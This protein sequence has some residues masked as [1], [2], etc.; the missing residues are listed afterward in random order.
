MLR[1][2][3]LINMADQVDEVKQ[4]TDIVT[5]I[6]GYIDLKKS[7][8]NFKAVC[9]FHSEKTPSFMVSPELQIYKCFG[10]GESGDVYSF[11]QKYEGMDFYEALQFLAQRS[12]VKLETANFED[13]EGK[14]KLF[15]INNLAIKFYQYLLLNHKAGKPALNYLLKDRGLKIETIKEFGLGYSP[16]PPEVISK[17]L[18]NKKGFSKSDLERAGIVYRR[19]SRAVD[20]FKG[21]ITFPLFDHRGNAVGFS[22]RLMPQDDSGDAAKYINTPETPVYHKS[23]V[24]YALNKTRGD[25]K[26]IGFAIVVEGELDALSPWQAGF[27]NVVA[28]KGSAFTEDQARLLSRFTES[29]VLALDADLAGDTASRRGINIAESAGLAVKVAIMK[30][31][32][33]PDEMVR[34]DAVAFEHAVKKAVG[35]WDFIIDSI[36]SGGASETS[37]GKAKISREIIPVLASIEDEIVKAHYLQVTANRLDVPVAAVVDQLR[38][39]KAESDTKREKIEEI[40]EHHTKSRRQLLEERLLSISFEIDPEALLDKKILNLIETPL[41]KKI[42]EHYRQYTVKNKTFIPS[43]F[44]ESLPKELVEGFADLLLKDTSGEETSSEQQKELKLIEKEL[45]ILILKT[46]LNEL[47]KL[48]RGYEEKNQKT[49]LQGVEK[50]FS[51]LSRK[52]TELE[53]KDFGGII[54]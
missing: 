24:L 39:Y 38:K 47:A 13:R 2:L 45:Y 49:K 26:K 4:K 18:V 48:M 50:K 7:G 1:A 41:P 6:G 40:V 9:P 22:G 54:L 10:C 36:F 19:G 30:G 16:K 14:R 46:K 29:V 32:K 25:I 15:E 11:L 12:G 8:R 27:T 20:R 37:E 31:F 35:V 33:D 44:A 5:V 28:I 43:N 42:L 34:S 23:R 21:R 51:K 53:E 17:F 52:L 3:V